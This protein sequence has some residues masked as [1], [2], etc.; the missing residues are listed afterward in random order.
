MNPREAI[1]I[2]MLSPIYFQL[3]L[4]QRRKLV[5]EYCRLFVQSEP[6]EER[7]STI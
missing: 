7:K 2:L 1:R 5:F 6:W 4:A 3:G